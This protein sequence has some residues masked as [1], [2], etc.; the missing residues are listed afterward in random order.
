VLLL[1]CDFDFDLGD[2]DA[3][4]ADDNKGDTAGGGRRRPRLLPLE[5]D[6]EEMGEIFGK[7]RGET[8]GMTR[9]FREK[10]PNSI[11]AQQQFPPYSASVKS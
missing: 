11:S 9:S 1:L 10:L 6:G 7:G 8:A 2:A 5:W 4:A 3:D